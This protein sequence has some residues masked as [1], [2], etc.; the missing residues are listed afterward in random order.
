MTNANSAH[1]A[2]QTC[3]DLMQVKASTCVVLCVCVLPQKPVPPVPINGSNLLYLLLY[4]HT[5]WQ[6]MISAKKPKKVAPL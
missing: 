4:C 2:P 5:G 1:P 3:L 6:E